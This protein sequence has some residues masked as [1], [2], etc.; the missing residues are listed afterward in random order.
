[1][2]TAENKLQD[3]TGLRNTPVITPY[4]LTQK[5]NP[6]EY[7]KLIIAPMKHIDRLWNVAKGRVR[8]LATRNK[9]PG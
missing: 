8:A 7:Q 4:K 6:T 1:M 3:L 9:F 5:S 2:P